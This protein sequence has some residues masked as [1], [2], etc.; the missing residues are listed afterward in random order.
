MSVFSGV[1]LP[2]I[3]FRVLF[4][5]FFSASVFF[6]FASASIHFFTPDDEARSIF[7]LE[8]DPDKH[9]FLLG[10][11]TEGGSAAYAIFGTATSIRVSFSP[12]SSLS[13]S[14]VR[15]IQGHR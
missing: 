12:L 2:L 8:Q 1:H 3:E 7:R 6:S 5:S 4:S 14:L 11:L 9:Y 13:R 10:I 15:C